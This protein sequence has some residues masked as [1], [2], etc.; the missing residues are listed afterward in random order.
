MLDDPRIWK[1]LLECL[2]LL[3]AH[4]LTA[5]LDPAES[6]AVL[7]E[8]LCV[9]EH[10]PPEGGHGRDAVDLPL[11]EHLSCFRRV[12]AARGDV[13][14][15]AYERHGPATREAERVVCGHAQVLAHRRIHLHDGDDPTRRV[16]QGAVGDQ[17]RLR[18]ALG[19]RRERHEGDVRCLRRFITRSPVPT[20]GRARDGRA[21]RPR[22]RD[23][24][25]VIRAP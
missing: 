23:A 5:D 24:L 2:L 15:A 10:Q 13:D 17:N 1:Q 12:E 22:D 20:R 4:E 8:E 9:A 11:G 7:G 21:L 16:G 14:L 3:G 19:A 6:V 18:R 25:V